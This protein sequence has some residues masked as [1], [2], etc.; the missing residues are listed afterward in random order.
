MDMKDDVFNLQLG[1]DAQ[2]IDFK[3][4]IFSVKLFT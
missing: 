3:G 4:L 2:C 1:S